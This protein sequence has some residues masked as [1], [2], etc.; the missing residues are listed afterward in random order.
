MAISQMDTIWFEAGFKDRLRNIWGLD[1]LTAKR[2][3]FILMC[4]YMWLY[5]SLK[6]VWGSLGVCRAKMLKINVELSLI[7]WL[8]E[9]NKLF[10]IFRLYKF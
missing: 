2:D 8:Y 1:I 4:H 9:Q 3:F 6:I 10:L 7:C 5:K